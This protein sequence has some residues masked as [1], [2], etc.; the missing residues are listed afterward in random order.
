MRCKDD[1]I[2]I[3]SWGYLV[4]TIDYKIDAR[5]TTYTKLRASMGGWIGVRGKIQIYKLLL[6]FYIFDLFNFL[7]GYHLSQNKNER[8][9]I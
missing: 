9:N 8:N 7:N 4:E 6:V 3:Q 1:F 2:S 5:A